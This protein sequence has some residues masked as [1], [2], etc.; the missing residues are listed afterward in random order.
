MRSKINMMIMAIIAASALWLAG[1]FVFGH[2]VG[3]VCVILGIGIV[4]LAAGNIMNS[5]A[6]EDQH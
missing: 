4:G 1:G 6:P 3:M 5:P 2:A